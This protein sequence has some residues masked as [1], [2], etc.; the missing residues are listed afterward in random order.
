MPAGL[1][2]LPALLPPWAIAAIALTVF[3][4]AAV[5]VSLGMGFGMAAA[6]LLALIDPEL[7]PAPVLMLGLATASFGAWSE[8]SGIDW[9]E[10]ATGMTGRIAGVIAALALMS[11]LPQERSFTLVFG[12]LVLLAVALSASG[13][14]MAFTRTNLIAMSSLSGLMGTFTSVGAPPLALIYQNRPPDAARP[15]LAAFF[16][17]GCLVALG[18]LFA[19]GRT[20]LHDA[21]LAALMAPPMLAGMVLGR[22]VRGRF[23][24]RYRMALLGIAGLAALLLVWRGLS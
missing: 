18:G 5:Q 3:L 6:P 1:M 4:A 8:R 15:T 24:R 19:A 22:R 2:T 14:R 23:D 20:G 16:A 11:A 7:V 21:A 13:W 10:V 9:S 17:L 12:I